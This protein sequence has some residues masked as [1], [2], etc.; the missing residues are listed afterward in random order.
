M[1]EEGL[2]RMERGNE[3]MSLVRLSLC[4]LVHT[5]TIT[6][7][8]SQEPGSTQQRTGYKSKEEWGGMRRKGRRAGPR[9]GRE[10]GRIQPPECVRVCVSGW[11]EKY[12]SEECR[13]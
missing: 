13:V 3:G 11:K 10:C 4:L 8:Q 1:R 9:E 12:W 7:K 6:S 2:L 5:H